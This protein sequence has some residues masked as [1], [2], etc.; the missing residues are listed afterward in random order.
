MA[1]PSARLVAVPPSRGEAPAGRAEIAARAFGAADLLVEL[2][3]GLRI[4][5]VAGAADSLIGRDAG[6]LVGLPAT[7][8]VSPQ[9]R[10]QLLDEL[11]Q[12][13]GPKHLGAMVVRLRRADGLAPHVRLAG[14]RPPGAGRY[15]H[16]AFRLHSCYQCPMAEAEGM[17][18]LRPGAGGPASDIHLMQRRLEEFAREIADGGDRPGGGTAD[19]AGVG[20]ALVYAINRYCADMGEAFSV[21]Q[22]SAGL[23][24]LAASAAARVGAYRATVAGGVFD[25]AF[26]PIVD[27]DDGSTQHYEVLVRFERTKLDVSPFEFITFAEQ[28]GLI[29]E[30]DLAMCRKVLEFLSEERNQDERYIL[31]VNLSAGSLSAPA[32]ASSLEALLGEYEQVRGQLMF[33]VTESSKI[34]DLPAV[35][36]FLQRLRRAGH[37]VCLDD[38]GSGAAAFQYLRAL[39]V[40][41]VKI[42]GGYVKNACA[43]PEGKRFLMAMAGLLRELGITTIAEMVEDEKHLEVIKECGFRFGQGYLF[44]RPSVDI[45]AFSGPAPAV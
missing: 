27:L 2:D 18:P 38:F 9:D 26:Q 25:T 3:S 17:A 44:G 1:L 6:T 8:L 31:A 23:G 15:W 36:A 20:K 11:R 10:P 45:D 39:Q 40:D 37:K 30:F 12:A 22:L 24:E 43:T 35:N 16:L 32:F 13:G 42:D 19:A 29:H 34:T 21:A 14:Y 5:S 28:V 41:V 7:E 4:V 33:E